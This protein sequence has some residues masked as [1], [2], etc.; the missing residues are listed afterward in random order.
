MGTHRVRLLFALFAISGFTG[1][2]YESIWSH[3][4]K[5][6]LGSAAFAQSF[7]LAV[8]MGGMA[9][10]A[11]IA[12][13]KSA[14]IGNLLAMYGWIE[15]FIGVAALAFHEVYIA[16]TEASLHH[17]IP[18]LG[19]PLAVEI[20]KYALCGILIVPQTIL[21]GM[22]FPLMSGSVI[23]R[24]PG[25]SGHHL[26]MLYFTN[27]TGAAAGVL[28]AAF[29][30]LDWLGMPGTMRLAGTINL[31]LA[32]VVL[33]LARRSEPPAALP[34][35]G[36][37][38]PA[39]PMI[40]RLFLAGAFVTGVASFIY[41]IAWIRML[42]LVLGS[43]FQA[44]ELMLCAF[45]TGLALGGLWIRRRI[46]TIA[47]PVRFAGLI[48]LAM[49]LAAL[50]TVFIYHQS[51]D[52]M[53]GALHVLQRNE[54]A[55]PLFNLFSHA[56]AFAVMVPA[57]FL[58]GMTLP[59]FTHVMLRHGHGERAIGQ[60]YSANTLG[61]I[62]G[63][64]L[65][66]HVLIPD[67]GVK[68]TL[69]AGAALDIVLGGWLLRYSA[70][71]FRRLH[72]FA[73]IIAGLSASSATA[74]ADILQPERL[75]SGVYRYGRAVNENV[76][77]IYY[78]DGKTA[79]ISVVSRGANLSILTNGKPDAN[80]NMDPA[81]LP[82]G[83]EYTMTLLGALPLLLKPDARR[84]A[85]IGFGSGLTGEV[86]LSHSGPTELHTIEIEPSV[87]AGARAFFPRVAKPFR[88]RRSKVFYEDAKSYLARHGRT[89]D[90]IVSEPS[91]PWV[92][93]VA[94]L[95]T[96]E[97]YRD[98]KRYLAPGGLF[99][100]WLHLYEFDDRLLSSIL[101]AL[102]ENFSDYEIYDTNGG[103]LVVIATASGRVP[104]LG[105]LPAHEVAFMDQ[106]KRV[107]MDS[108]A[109]LL[110]R[111]IGNKALLEKY[112]APLGAPVNSD[113]Y[114]YVQ[115]HSAR[116]RYAQHSAR[117]IHELHRSPLPIVEF[118]AS[119]DRLPLQDTPIDKSNSDW[120]H[121]QSLA[122]KFAR[123]LLDGTRVSAIENEWP[124]FSTLREM[125]RTGAYCGAQVS[126]G[127]MEHLH[128]AA[129]L[130]LT[131]LPVETRKKIWVDRDWLGC[132]SAQILPT[133]RERLDIY[134]A[135]STRDA[136]KMLA[137]ARAALPDARKGESKDWAQFVLLTAILGAK[138][139]GDNASAKA[140]WQAHSGALYGGSDTIPL[141]V[142]F[143]AG[144]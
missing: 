77:V 20:F 92:N 94:G 129:E 108:L 98:A 45:I 25:S 7:V 8:F 72:A 131:T 67:M 141:Y 37:M 38:N 107:G 27:S 111:N 28:C 50:S 47:D 97:F 15:A 19:S 40:V 48:Q 136:V 95:F 73:A 41:E 143:L 93:G 66:V 87:I 117:A 133:I 70:S 22:T 121:Y 58:A 101:S 144:F 109:A 90:V 9:I 68:L 52:W 132:A 118:I 53:A 75:S 14:R 30:L 2:I 10:G 89:Y 122:Q 116:L 39:K 16:L 140:L 123:S 138:A 62:A 63:V 110:G 13:R 84:F 35:S 135:I 3:Y 29:V 78:A 99:V 54:S 137:L 21:L 12:S 31:A 76:R 69:I 49:G 115:L 32:G 103:D 105:S 120:L 65:A 88:D 36:E 17:V 124:Q 81:T 91:N 43:S 34:V 61:A 139:T 106:L 142:K 26:A 56:I 23:R 44:F 42:S 126:S 100:Q 82:T 119:A 11:W 125:T 51:F 102:G 5:L 64:L 130:T 46:D 113:F 128:K 79:S 24:D 85:N 83:D 1:L 104:R 80:I 86:I 96:T 114:P 33:V 55:Y 74:L 6:F 57:T 4:L 18:Q 60:I 127:A 134:A 71:A 59:L 112:F